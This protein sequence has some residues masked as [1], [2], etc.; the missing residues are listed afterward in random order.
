[1]CITNNNNSNKYNLWQFASELP[2]WLPCAHSVSAGPPGLP[3]GRSLRLPPIWLWILVI[4]DYQHYR[5]QVNYICIAY[6]MTLRCQRNPYCIDEV[7]KIWSYPTYTAALIKYVG[8]NSLNSLN[9]FQHTLRLPISAPP[10]IANICITPTTP[11]KL[12][13]LRV[14]GTNFSRLK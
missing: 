11:F 3:R 7:N 9:D 13:M 10:F 12:L 5:D 1:M 14:K 8:Q 4:T 6:H 2:R